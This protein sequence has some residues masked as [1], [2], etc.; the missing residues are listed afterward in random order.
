MTMND[1]SDE[2]SSDYKDADVSELATTVDQDELQRVI[3]H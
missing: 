3:R 1:K 2:P